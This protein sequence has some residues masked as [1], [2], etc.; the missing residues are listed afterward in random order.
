MEVKKK[1]NLITTILKK[2]LFDTIIQLEQQRKVQSRTKLLQKNKEGKT[3][4]QGLLHLPF[5]CHLNM[6]RTISYQA[7]HSEG[8][9][10]AIFFSF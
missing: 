10:Y 5:H 2:M 7:F 6:Q 1:K 4:F 8:M 3:L 9:Q